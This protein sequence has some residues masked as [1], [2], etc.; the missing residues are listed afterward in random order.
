MNYIASHPT[1][2]AKDVAEVLKVSV[3][4]VYQAVYLRKKK[5]I[6]N[7]KAIAVSTSNKSFAPNARMSKALFSD[8]PQRGR[9]F[10]LRTKLGTYTKADS[11][12]SP[13]HYKVGGVE[14]IDFIEAKKLGYNLGNVVKYV[15]RADYKGRLLE[16]LKKAQWYLNR[17]IQIMEKSK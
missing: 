6:S 7:L 10:K 14:T 11:V 5:V 4:S 12:N 13:A 17:E 15:S 16:D 1:A 9:P 3:N 2:K 8:T